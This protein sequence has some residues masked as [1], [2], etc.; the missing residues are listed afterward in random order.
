M[1]PNLER[2]ITLSF[3]AAAVIL[4]FAATRLLQ[5]FLYRGFRRPPTMFE[6]LGPYFARAEPWEIWLYLL[7]FI[8][9]PALALILVRIYEYLPIHLRGRRVLAMLG[10]A[11]AAVLAYKLVPFILNLDWGVY[12]T[13]LNEEGAKK[14]FWLLLTKRIFVSRVVLAAAAATFLLSL[15]RPPKL[16][17]LQNLDN[18]EV[19]RSLEPAVLLMLGILLFHPNLPFQDHHYYYFLGPVN[20]I[21]SGKALLYETTS[22]YGLLNI[23]FLLPIFKFFLPFSYPAFSLVLFFFNLGFFLAIY[24]FLKSWLSSRLWP[25]LGVAA[26]YTIFFLLASSPSRTAYFYPGSTPF[27]FWFLVPILFLILKFARTR[28]LIFANL[29][30]A[31]SALAFFWNLDSG[32]FLGVAVFLT[33][34]VM[35][36]RGHV[37]KNFARLSGKFLLAIAAVWGAIS[38]INLAVYGSLPNWFLF[39][40]EIRP[41][42]DGIGMTPLP[43]IGVFEVFV[44]LY[45]ALLIRVWQKVRAG[46]GADPILVFLLFYGIFSTLY[47]I[48]ESSWQNLPIISVVPVILAAYIFKTF[49]DSRVKRA[50]FAAAGVLV[51]LF[52]AVKLPVEFI[53]RNYKYAPSLTAIPRVDENL[54]ADARDIR[55]DYESLD[56]LPLLHLQDV[57]LL[58]YA[59]KANWFNFY[60][61][62]SLYYR[63]DIEKLSAQVAA[64]QPQYLFIGQEKN[65]QIEY[66]LKLLPSD[67]RK[68]KTLRT[69]EV[70]ERQATIPND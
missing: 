29:A 44:L 35:G 65:D 57:K 56:R 31:V 64:E 5:D 54:A 39:L 43:L 48:G 67:Y 50:A 3:L 8:A 37:I 4:Y 51:L 59:R 9:I 47:Y 40:R 22:L 2:K 41:F 53:N 7:G 36:G 63:E 30:I 24:Y 16:V 34:W 26:L 20:D 68:T 1:F 28:R 27:R 10:L 62:F 25:V 42:G 58:F 12:W 61:L 11:A 19:W 14:T 13:Y 38:L 66:F 70:W 32:A 21:F 6:S 45:I 15:F 69:L 23:Y 55:R 60:Y 52:L 33:L 18:H 49:P 46:E 17:R